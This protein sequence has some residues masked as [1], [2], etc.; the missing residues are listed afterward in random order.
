MTETTTKAKSAAPVTAA[1]WHQQ[2]NAL[3]DEGKLDRAI[4]AFR[5]ALRMDDGLAEVHNDL[6]TAYFQKGWH[7]EA[8]ACF[9]KAIDLKPE[10][11]IAQANLG[12]ALRGANH[13]FERRF[14]A[15]EAQAEAQGT[16][17]ASLDLDAQEALWQHAKAAEKE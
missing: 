5:R 13:K 4:S 8:E 9:R 17:L 12:A 2:G 10:H 7:A 16:S 6:G 11:G 3:L 14:R 1:E 15:M